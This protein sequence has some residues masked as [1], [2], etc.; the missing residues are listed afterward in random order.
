MPVFP[1]PCADDL[2]IVVIFEDFGVVALTLLFL[3][4]LILIKE[5]DSGN[6]S[7]QAAAFFFF[8]AISTA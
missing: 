6:L 1:L 3:F 8:L 5:Q 4:Y 2:A 7:A